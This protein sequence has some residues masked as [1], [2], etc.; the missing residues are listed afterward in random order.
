MFEYVDRLIKSFESFLFR[1]NEGMAETFRSIGLSYHSITAM[2]FLLMVVT[3]VLIIYLFIRVGLVESLLERDRENRYFFPLVMVAA[4]VDI[5][6]DKGVDGLEFGAFMALMVYG[7]YKI[8][9]CSEKYE[10]LKEHI[11]K[12]F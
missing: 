4:I 8:V 6:L 12:L 2:E 11:S 10:W 9:L 3:T 1:Y 5:Y 7:F